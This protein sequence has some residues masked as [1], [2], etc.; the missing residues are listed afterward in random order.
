M[1]VVVPGGSGQIGRLIQGALLRSGHEVVVL[2]RSPGAPGDVAWD[3]KTLGPWASALEGADFV[4]NLAGRSVDCR[5]TETN[6]QQMMDS[7]TWSTQVVGEAIELA[8]NPPPLWLQ[9]STATIYAHRFD[10]DNDEADGIIGGNEPDAPGYWKRSIEIAKAWE[11][12]LARANTPHTRKVALRT[13]MVMAPTRGGIFDVLYRLTRLGLGGSIGGGE[14]FV[15][16]IHEADFVHALDFV[17]KHEEIEGVINLAAPNPLRQKEFQRTLRQAAR[18]PIGLPASKWM[19]EIG[20]FVRR[21]DTELLLKSR[22]VYPRRLLRAGFEFKFPNWQGAAQD[23]VGEYKRG[24][25]SL[26]WPEIEN[27]AA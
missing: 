21:T 18:I 20:A 12:T 7:R 14:Q 13:A 8:R 10:A 2:T 24:Q 11:A 23:L 9:M 16:W 19:A 3:G 25:P 5:Y 26:T 17:R 1:K 6:L 27:Q 4:L 15:S 22:R